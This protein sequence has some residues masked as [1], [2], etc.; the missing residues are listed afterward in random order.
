MYFLCIQGI[1]YEID[2]DVEVVP[3]PGH[4]GADISV[5]V[6]NTELGTVAVAGILTGGVRKVH[7]QL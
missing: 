1:P 2:D 5:I 7:G 3:T 4:T 6:S